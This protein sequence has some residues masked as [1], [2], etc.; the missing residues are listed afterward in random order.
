MPNSNTEDNQL[1]VQGYNI[2]TILKRLE[3]ATSRLEDITIFQEEANRA[4]KLGT[5][6]PQSVPVAAS[7]TKPVAASIDDSKVTPPP[8]KPKFIGEFELLVQQRVSPFV[9]LSKQIDPLLGEAATILEN[10]FNEE[11]KFLNFVSESKKPDSSDPALLE[12]IKPI[13]EGIIEISA[14]KDKNFRSEYPKHLSAFSDGAPVV[15]WIVATAPVD[16]VSDF[17]ESAQFWTNKVMTEF[18]EKDP[19]HVEWVKTFMAIFDA[20]IAYVRDYHKT[21]PSWN[22]QG[23]TLTES[24]A[25]TNEGKTSH[26]PAADGPPAPPPP[27]PSNLFDETPT[28]KAGGI[29]AVFAD[30]NKGALVTSGLKKVDKSQMTHKNPELRKQDPVNKRPPPPKK[31]TNLSTASSIPKKKP[32]RKELVDGTKWI[33]ENFTEADTHEPIK[34]EVERTQSVFIGK[35]SGVTI[36]IQGKGN[37]VSISDTVKTGVVV[38][39]LISGIDVIKSKKFGLQVTGLV[40]LVSVDNSEE[41]SI[42]LSQESVSAESQIVSSNTTALNINILKDEDYVELPVPEQISHTIK[43]GKLVSEVVEHA[44]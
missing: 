1:N 12:A 19:R 30:L 14:L 24:L 33:V 13:N 3:T 41:G 29:G 2:V 36:Q 22:A 11:T 5:L 43:D 6:L 10:A 20:L 38:D 28:P 21:G 34:I 39:S 23:R 40:P 7:D 18:K 4:S 35:T 17:K 26:K 27:P 32:A 31:P 42:Y 8:K 15:G 37:A 25:A 44:G 16:Y 9:D